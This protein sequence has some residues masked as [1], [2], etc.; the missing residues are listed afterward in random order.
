[1]LFAAARTAPP[2]PDRR[3]QEKQ[4]EA[5]QQHVHP[6][7]GLSFVTRI[8]DPGEREHDPTNRS[9]ADTPRKDE[10]QALRRSSIRAEHEHHGDDRHREDRDRDG[11]RQYVS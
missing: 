11:Q 7:G 5:E 3:H 2:L 1:V 6:G 10:G 9:Q 8:R 4:A